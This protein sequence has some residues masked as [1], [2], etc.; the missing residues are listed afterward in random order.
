PQVLAESCPNLRHL[1]LDRPE[2]RHLAPELEHAD[3]DEHKASGQTG[4]R[5]YAHER[6]YRFVRNT[7]IHLCA[8][9]ATGQAA[10][11]HI[12]SIDAKSKG[13]SIFAVSIADK[14]V[15]AL[16]DQGC[17]IGSGEGWECECLQFRNC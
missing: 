12:Q 7:F 9:G 4:A 13:I 15:A 5:Y 2:M 11:K 3:D 17:H 10:A 8:S 1:S 6:S 14:G 16:L